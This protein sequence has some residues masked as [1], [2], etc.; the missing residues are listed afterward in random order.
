M[1]NTFKMVIMTSEVESE[2]IVFF[3]ILHSIPISKNFDSNLD[4]NTEINLYL[5]FD[6]VLL[7]YIIIFVIGLAIESWFRSH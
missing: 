6:G 4:R 5:R 3:K 1:K 2:V 7:V